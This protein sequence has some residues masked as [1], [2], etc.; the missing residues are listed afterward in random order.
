MR[1]HS[2][3]RPCDGTSLTKSR[4]LRYSS[5]PDPAVR[6][7][8]GL[9][10]PEVGAVDPHA[11]QYHRQFARQCHLCPFHPALL[12]DAQRPGLQCREPCHP[13]ED[14]IGRF[15]QGGTYHHVA[16]FS[17]PARPV[18]LTGLIL[19]W[20]QTKIRP[21]IPGFVKPRRIVDCAPMPGAVM[22]R[23][24]TA[25]A[26]TMRNSNRCSLAYSARRLARACSIAAVT[27]SSMGC[28]AANSRIRASYLLLL[29]LPTFRPKPRS[30][31]RMPSSTSC[32]LR[33]SK[34]RALSSARTSCAGTAFT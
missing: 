16:D 14:D 27:G 23:R 30:R 3:A 29:T 25:S 2:T 20:R 12:G 13:G 17:D 21:E 6:L 5:M 32:N 24:Q 33:C 31:P 34:S 8:C 26:R 22:N 19:T 7:G 10:P 9:A 15:K 4:A 18:D 11:M 28:P 1:L